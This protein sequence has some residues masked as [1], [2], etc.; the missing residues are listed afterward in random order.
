[1][2]QDG[3]VNLAV[4]GSTGDG[5]LKSGTAITAPGQPNVVYQVIGPVF[6]IL[7]RFIKTYLTI[8]LAIIGAGFTTDV[9]PWHAFS[10]LV[11]VS[12]KLALS[13]ALLNLGKDVLTVFT[14][15]EKR[16]PLLLGNV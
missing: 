10:D 15:L 9:L 14:D 6:A 8:F 11:A 13:G 12:W 3:I 4:I 2:S 1:M 7:I 16:F 5:G